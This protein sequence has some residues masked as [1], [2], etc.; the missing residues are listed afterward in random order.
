MGLQH[1]YRNFLRG[2]QGQQWEYSLQNEPSRQLVSPLYLLFH[3][4]SCQKCTVKSDKVLFFMVGRM[5]ADIC[6]HR[7]FLFNLY[8]CCLLNLLATC[9]FADL[10]SRMS[11]DLIYTCHCVQLMSLYFGSFLAAIYGFLHSGEVF[12]NALRFSL[13]CRSTKPQVWRVKT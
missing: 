8:R 3:C 7:A 13:A 12:L 1:A 4:V 11:F 9:S 2:K 6:F 10:I 5:K